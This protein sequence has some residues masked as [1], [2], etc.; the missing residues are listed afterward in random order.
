MHKQALPVLQAPRHSSRQSAAIEIQA[1][2]AQAR[3]FEARKDFVE[4]TRCWQTFL[5]RHPEHAEAANELGNIF[6]RMERFDD[7]LRWFERALKIRPGLTAAKISAGIALR[8]LMRFEEAVATFREVL[9]STP[10]EADACLHLGLALRAL[11]RHDEAL[12]W[13]RKASDL[14]PSHAQS[15]NELGDVLTVL[16]RKEE[17]IAAYQHAVALQPD[18]IPVLQSFGERLQDGRRFEEAAATF[19]KIVELDP[20]HC[21][22]WLS[23]G[24]A[25][26]GLHQ[27]ADSLAAFR[28]ALALEP[29]SAAGYCN[30]SLALMG[31]DRM[32]EAIEACRKALFIEAGSPVASFNL[33]CALL[34]QGSFREGWALYDYRFVMGGNKW[35]RPEAHAA[36]WT[37][38]PPAG[39]SILVL[40]EQGNGDLIQFSR[41]L[42]AL[43]DLGASVSFLA[44]QRLHQLF[45]TLGGSIT[46]LSEVPKDAH[47]DFQCPLMSLPGRFDR[48]DLPIPDQPYLKAEPERVAKWRDSIGDDGFLVGVAWR[49]NRYPEGDGFRSFRLDALRP[50]AALPNVRLISLQLKEGKEEIEKLPTDM[51]IE[52]PGPDFDAGPDGFL[53]SAAILAL[54]DLVI[55]CDTSIAHLAGA[56]GRRLWIALNRTP[57]WRWRRQRADT[58]WYPTAR[59]FRQETNGDWDGV[60]SRMRNELLQLLQTRKGVSRERGSISRKAAPRVE[61]SWGDLLDRIAMSEAESKRRPGPD[62]NAALLCEL[63]HLKS[64]VAEIEPILASVEAQRAALRR[65]NEKLWDLKEAMRLCE[66][67]NR[68]DARFIQIAREM[69][70]LEDERT[71]MKQEINNAVE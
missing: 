16:K 69:Q 23:L 50:L 31:L 25:L 53:D 34:T 71:R 59:L 6:V 58:V 43:N 30:M 70:A 42:P 20:N 52:V 9:L 37:G 38:E 1:V 17:A 62:A 5:E 8:H 33:G 27:Y 4:A 19:R 65:I 14:R 55:S 44:P 22:G 57:E 66:I 39:K 15:A 45:R 28:R 36:P 63:Q 3:L 32:E 35:L 26:L 68:F 41:Y 24:A 40:G 7:G 29:G 61:L 64:I 49:G 10:D 51:H 67:E 47:F 48:L 21:N 12:A 13:L 2:R 60:F 56:L 11:Q 54:M 46:L 18:S